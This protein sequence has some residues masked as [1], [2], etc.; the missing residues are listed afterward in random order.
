MENLF[1]SFQTSVQQHFEQFLVHV[2]KRYRVDLKKL[3]AD[4]KQYQMGKLEIL[5]EEPVKTAEA[6]KDI[7]ASESDEASEV[8]TRVKN[9]IDSSEESVDLDEDSEQEV[10]LEESKESEEE[11]LPKKKSKVVIQDVDSDEESMSEAE[12][13]E[14]ED[15]DDEPSESEPKPKKKAAKATKEKKGKS[16]DDLSDKPKTA[17]DA[18]VPKG[19]SIDDLSDKPKTASDAKVPKGTQFLKGTNLVVV[20]G[21]VVAALTKKGFVKLD[22]RYLKT[23]EHDDY[24]DIKYEVWEKDKIEKKLK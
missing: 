3:Q 21:K 14:S 5:Q 15:E 7:E 1:A 9:V 6:M 12:A 18:K 11:P 19:K 13:P 17:S 2:S 20:K 23:F 8:K 22:K 4:F 16:I 10:N 24:K